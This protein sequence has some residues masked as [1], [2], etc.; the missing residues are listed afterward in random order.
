MLRA[1]AV[2]L[3]VAI[4]PVCA[5]RTI[6]VDPNA[7]GA[8]NGDSWT[9]AYTYLQQA[10][11]VAQSGDHLRLAQGRYQPDLGPTAL[12]G[13]PNATFTLKSGVALH[14]GF[15]G[16]RGADP[17]QRDRTL[18]PTVLTGDLL[19]NDPCSPDWDTLLTD[20][21]RTDNAFHVITATSVTSTAVLDGLVVTG[22][23]ALG[24]L[25][26]GGGLLNVSG[27]PMIV[28][29]VFLENV[30][31]QG[32]A[33]AN[34]TSGAAYFFN[35]RFYRN[36]AN[37]HGGAVFNDLSDPQFTNCTF[38][39]NHAALWD[40]GAVM[41]DHSHPLL[42]NCT[43]VG[44]AAGATGFGGG[45]RNADSS[46][47]LT[48]CILWGNSAIFGVSTE[49]YQIHG[50]SPLVKYT[51]VQG[52]KEFVGS[53]NIAAYPRFVDADGPDGVLGTADDDVRLRAGSPC[54]DAGDS[55]AVPIDWG[56]V[57]GDGLRS[58]QTPLDVAGQNRFVDDPNTSDT[59]YPVSP[60]VD[61]GAYEGPVSA[62]TNSVLYVD[63]RAFNGANDGSSWANAF[64][65]VQDAL[66]ASPGGEIRIAAGTYRPD[67]G[68]GIVPGDQQASF[69]LKD[70]VHL[71][72]GYMGLAHADPDSRAPDLFV[73]ILSGDLQGDDE[74]NMAHYD[75]NSAHVVTSSGT[76]ASAVL[77][78]VTIRAGNANGQAGGILNWGGALRCFESQAT[79]LNCRFE[80]NRAFCGGALAN[81]RGNPTL[82]ECSFVGNHAEWAGG[83]A[84]NFESQSQWLRCEF[85][86]NH[87]A[88]DGGALYNDTSTI[89]VRQSTML[90]NSAGENGGAVADYSGGTAGSLTHTTLENC[91]IL[92]NTA[93]FAGG[94]YHYNDLDAAGST[95]TLSN[96]TLVG[97]RDMDGT[98]HLV[99]NSY[100][101]A[102]PSTI[103]ISNT[104]L[105]DPDVGITTL[106]GSTITLR[107]SNLPIV[108]PGV[109][110]FV[111]DPCFAGPGYW[112]PNGTPT[113]L[114]D[115][116]WHNGDFHLMSQAGCWDP[117]LGAW[118]L[119]ETTSP[120]VDAGDP[121]S[122]WSQELYPNG[123]R[124]NL[125]A[126]G[127]TAHA[128]KSLSLA[129]DPND[130]N[131]DG[132]VNMIDYS[133]IGH[134]YLRPTQPLRG[135]L[136][137]SGVV[138]VHD[139]AAL[140]D[141]W[142]WEVP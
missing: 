6:Y 108:W 110:N 140:L 142:L 60:V 68:V 2:T 75:D 139:L 120:C 29:C 66:A 93:S 97:N 103:M 55:T 87:A 115:D 46:P 51:C 28:N 31:G 132:A 101:L 49:E 3:L 77:D 109:G 119:D 22:G 59:G 112:D 64:W 122:P 85:V 34:L 80:A 39:G 83:A 90:G 130:L 52:L 33:V 23:R 141:K 12:P 127:N 98:S 38:L 88:R 15:A 134:N 99:S 37:H 18:Y 81:D 102:Y 1:L 113:D 100:L 137:D 107:Y 16:V 106:D 30:A 45:L 117:N 20:P 71:K 138:D 123:Q 54:I 43:V 128:S 67:V 58:E 17:D 86:A 53:G 44:N 61:M 57:D 74:P 111:D 114:S 129:G 73:T 13:D 14:G 136:D 8:G 50:G 40:G 65:S 79:F 70:A 21:N 92:A 91:L 10:L 82:T 116:Q 42:V 5:G 125:G 94:L 7:T 84:A 26:S 25:P 69:C 19:A 95:A 47:Q 62:I 118:R 41:N 104:I 72:G 96:C 78:G 11:A 126:Y 9:D 135:D 4:A 56:D 27:Q 36:V 89:Y 63:W 35:C 48:N 105:G 32:G 131:G 24:D 133:I 121:A 124:V 76:T